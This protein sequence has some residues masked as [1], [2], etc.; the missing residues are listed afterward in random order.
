M[1]ARI[2]LSN[3][4]EVIMKK[5][6]D[7]IKSWTKVTGGR[8]GAPADYSNWNTIGMHLNTF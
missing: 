5:Y 4:Y 2:W 6:K 3:M 8:P 7:T 1:E